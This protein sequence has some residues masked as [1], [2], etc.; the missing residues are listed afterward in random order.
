MASIRCY[1]RL[2]RYQAL[3]VLPSA[4]SRPQVYS[5][6]GSWPAPNCIVDKSWLLGSGNDCAS[7]APSLQFPTFEL[8]SK[9]SSTNYAIDRG[10]PPG[11]FGE[12][13]A[14]TSRKIS[15]KFSRLI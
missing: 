10:D 11:L 7:R 13:C 12:T 1:G 4:P 2:E 15:R 3:I 9:R 14:T 8:R 6:I 5:A